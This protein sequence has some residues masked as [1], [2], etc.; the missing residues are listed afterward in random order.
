MSHRKGILDFCGSN[1]TVQFDING[2]EGKFGFRMFD[3][4]EMKIHNLVSRQP[5]IL[6]S[7]IIGKKSWGLWVNEFSDGIVEGCFTKK[8]IINE[9]IKH[10]ITIPEHLY[11]DFENRIYQ[12]MKKKFLNNLEMSF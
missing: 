11:I 10:G 9:F 6:R 1:V 12:K 5:N 2:P 4:G 3:N 7:V 8:E